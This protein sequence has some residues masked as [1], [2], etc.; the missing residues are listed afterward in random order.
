[1]SYISIDNLN[2]IHIELS[3]Y[4]NAACPMCPRFDWDGNLQEEYVNSHNITLELI[5]S[6]LEPALLS[7]LTS[8]WSNGTYG[9]G[10]VN[11]DCVE[12]FQ[13]IREHSP[14]C[15]L[16]LLT[17]GGPRN[18]KFWHDLGSIPR[19]TVLFS[20]DGLEDTNHLYR[21][22]VQWSKLM[23]NVQSFID[24]GGKAAWKM[25]VFRHNEHQIEEARQLANAM[26]FAGFSI[27]YSE[28]WAQRNYVHTDQVHVVE[29]WDAGG[30]FLEKPLSQPKSG[31][32]DPS[33]KKFNYDDNIAC[34]AC[35]KNVKEI[36]IRAN[37]QVQPCCMVGEIQRH[38]VGGLVDSPE[39]INLHIH[40][41]KNILEGSF[42]KRIADGIAGGPT[43]LQNC[44]Y[45][46]GHQER[47]NSTADGK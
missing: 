33:I 34:K 17:N 20:I 11:P 19:M 35:S 22:N 21:K 8:F 12:I 5:K 7:R 9:D 24:A 37:G 1:M 13:Y 25:I 2:Q 16:K 30:Y 10:A 26:G 28:R 6:R 14:T 36:Y 3:N 23:Q 44:F 15:N 38:E 40:S 43:R 39:D 31:M 4:C 45:V 27:Q 46:C 47:Y 41:L 18:K 32:V 29:K 42:F